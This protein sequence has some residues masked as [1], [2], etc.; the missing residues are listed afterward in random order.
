MITE[1]R[2]ERGIAYVT[3]AMVLD[4]H[5]LEGSREFARWMYGQTVAQTEAGETMIYADDYQR[6]AR[7][8]RPAD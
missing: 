1:F 3:L 8:L 2:S 4:E 7:G 5:G 6:W